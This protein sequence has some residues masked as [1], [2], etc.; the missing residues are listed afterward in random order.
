MAV[1]REEDR[2]LCTFPC[3]GDFG[4][5]PVGR[6]NFHNL[7]SLPRLMGEEE[8]RDESRE[9]VGLVSEARTTLWW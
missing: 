3:Y 2:N 9:L 1:A 5:P 7:I 6:S 8:S 4:G